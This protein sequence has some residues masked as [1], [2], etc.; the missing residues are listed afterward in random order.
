MVFSDPGIIITLQSMLAPL[1]QAFIVITSLGDEALLACCV[2]AVYAAGRR[3][4]ALTLAGSLLLSAG[5]NLVLKY[6]LRFERPPVELRRIAVSSYSFPSGHAQVSATFWSALRSKV[7]HPVVAPLGLLIVALVCL[8]R[9][10]L[11]VHYLGDVVAGVAIGALATGVWI[12]VEPRVVRLLSDVR[13]A[14][15]TGWAGAALVVIGGALVLNPFQ[16]TH[17][18]M[19]FVL[20]GLGFAHALQVDMPPPATER[21]DWLVRLALSLSFSTPLVFLAELLPPLPGAV[22]AVFAGLVGATAAQRIAA[23]MGA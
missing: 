13:N 16:P 22:P 17:A 6:T 15:L 12:L 4:I 3:R 21:P 8:S 19:A 18:T 23:R 1:D 7:S 14:H 9:L 2:V 11:G 20:A 10:Y 5:L